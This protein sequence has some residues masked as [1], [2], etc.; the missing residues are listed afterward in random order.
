MRFKLPGQLIPVAASAAVLLALYVS[1]CIAFHGFSSP[2]VLINLFGDNAFLGVA[3]VGATFVIL[4]GGIDLSVGAVVALTTISVAVLLEHGVPPLAAVLLV[5]A[6]GA[7][8]GTFLG[9]LIH[10]FELPPFLIT[11]GG[12]FLARGLGFV[13]RSESLGITHPFYGDT[14]GE[15]ALP[16]AHVTTASGRIQTIPLPFTAQCL[17]AVV[18]LATI[19]AKWTR[20]G[21]NV[22]AI[23]SSESSARLMGVPV[24]RTKILVY[25]LAGFLS[26]LGGVVA[27][28]YMQSGNPASFVGLE[29]DAIAAVVIGGT[30]LR[31]GVGFI[32]GTLIGV[33]ILGIIQT[34]INFKG[35]LNTWWTKIAIG[36]LLLVFIMLQQ[37]LSRPRRT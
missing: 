28:F 10:W 27:T 13:V 25:T 5:L 7:V 30:L 18:L 15:L 21:R 29:L 8:F 26:A 31:G 36:G 12:M 6:G 33:L 35:D 4:S 14:L 24:G 22:Y 32:P 23:G 34:L 2:R 1:G 37:A 16:V 17:L 20:F 9:W 19:A 11:L 3:A